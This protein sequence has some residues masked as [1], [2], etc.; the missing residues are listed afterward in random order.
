[1]RRILAVMALL[2]LAACGSNSPAPAPATTTTAPVNGAP[3][4]AKPLDIS[5]WQSNLCGLVSKSQSAAYKDAAEGS[6]RP[7]QVSGAKGCSYGYTNSSFALSFQTL[8]GQ[9]LGS[10]YGQK[11]NSD[12]FT[13]Y[14]LDGYPAVVTA[15]KGQVKSGVCLVFVGVRN[16]TVL[17]A[18]EQAEGG[19][20]AKEPCTAAKMAASW[21]MATITGK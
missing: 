2:S 15:P 9:G 18:Q 13:P 19:T 20:Y 14:Q 16:D 12:V 7:N 17:G 6:P 10:V 5:K 11:A 8:G 4:V 1:M 21:A 3:S